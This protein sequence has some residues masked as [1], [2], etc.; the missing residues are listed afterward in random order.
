MGAISE[1]EIAPIF[2]FFYACVALNLVLNRY[3]CIEIYSRLINMTKYPLFGMTLE[4]L[5][6]LVKRLGMPAFTAKQIASWLY[7]K[8]V[9]SIDDM[10]NL[11][12]K[13]RELLKVHRITNFLCII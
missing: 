10:T 11:S 8:R 2:V 1:K 12:L 6:T 13:F 5:Q 7:D 3:F 4:E 9:S